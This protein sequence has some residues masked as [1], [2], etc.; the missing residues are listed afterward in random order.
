[1]ATT[2]PIDFTRVTML[3]SHRPRFGWLWQSWAGR[4]ILA[5]LL[6]GLGVLAW[7]WGSI[8]GNA[9]TGAAVGARI[10]CSCH[11]IEGRPL[12]QCR[13]DFEPGMGLVT[14]SADETAKSVT[15]RVLMLSRQ[16]ATLRQGA[17]CVLE[18]W[19]N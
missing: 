18:P 13:D 11:F 12:A 5:L 14:L 4:G 16:T 15:A 1:M 6:V 17:G 8:S 7:F 9:V 2:K 10:A 19:G 3:L